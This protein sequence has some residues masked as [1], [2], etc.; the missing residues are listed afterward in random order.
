MADA[1]K[2][3]AYLEKHGLQAHF[4]AA[5]EHICKEMP[6]DP[7][8]AAA[9]YFLEHAKQAVHRWD[10]PTVFVNFDADGDGKLDI[11]EIAR[12]F[13]AMGFSKREGDDMEI[14]K[15]TEN[16]SFAR[17]KAGADGRARAR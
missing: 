13:R 10:L 3:K 12:A 2:T 17:K 16:H 8:K 15:V 1:E 4:Q 6:E 5:L 7:L 11:Y 9:T 14:D